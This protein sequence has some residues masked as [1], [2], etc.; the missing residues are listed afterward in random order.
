[1]CKFFIKVIFDSS[2]NFSKVNSGKEK[3]KQTFILII[4]AT[5]F[6]SCEKNVK[7][8]EGYLIEKKI[9]AFKFLSDYHHQLHIMI[10]EEDGDKKKALDEFKKRTSIK[11]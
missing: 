11:N 8:S 9:E 3:M 2:K 1:M 4:T 5:I 7:I 10:G 6:F